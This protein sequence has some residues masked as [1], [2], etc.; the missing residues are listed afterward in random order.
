[1]GVSE[2]HCCASGTDRGT[3]GRNGTPMANVRYASL[4]DVWK[5]LPLA[6]VFEI[7]RPG[8]YRESHAGSSNGSLGFEEGTL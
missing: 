8:R 2:V 5:H 1:V 3:F 4:G 7:E 6:E